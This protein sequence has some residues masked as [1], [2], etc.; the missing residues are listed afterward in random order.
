MNVPV[1]TREIHQVIEGLPSIE[2]ENET[3]FINVSG[4]TISDKQYKYI[5]DTLKLSNNIKFQDYRKV[6]GLYDKIVSIEMF[7]AVGKKDWSTYFKTIRKC[8]KNNG[9]AALQI[10]TINEEGYSSYEK[11][12]D[13]IQKYIFPGGMLPTKSLLK[14]FAIKNNLII[15]EK[16]SF[17]E[18][19]ARTLRIWRR[20]FLSKWDK[21]KKLGYDE[22][23]K[24]LWEYYLCYC[25]LGFKVGTID[26]S[27]FKIKKTNHV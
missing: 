7:E 11:N 2:V 8:L 16:R 26:V 4:I 18:D 25:E 20:N 5:N 3:L 27:Q 9:I 19:Y 23:F 15:E 1:L 21:I 22:E 24:R 14:K 17:G 6:N 12:K 13:F 10:I